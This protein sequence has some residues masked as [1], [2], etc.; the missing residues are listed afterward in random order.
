MN[1]VRDYTDLDLSIFEQAC[2]LYLESIH[3]TYFD[4]QMQTG[5]KLLLELR[6]DVATL[7]S[8]VM[9]HMADD[10][11]KSVEM[12]S[13][14]KVILKGMTDLHPFI[15]L[16]LISHKKSPESVRK[17]FLAMAKD[18][19]V[20]LIILALRYSSLYDLNVYDAPLRKKI[21]RETL[22]VYVPLAGRLGIYTIKRPLED[23]CFSFLSEED[24]KAMQ[25]AFDR[26]VELHEKTVNSLV[27]IIKKYLLTKGVVAEVSGRVK[28]LY[29][30]YS[31]LKRKGGGSLEDIYDLLALRIIVKDQMDCYSVL[32]H[33]NNEWIALSGRFKD[34]IAMP[35]ANG[36]RSLHTTVLGMITDFDRPV[37]VQ[38]RTE[39]MHREAEFGIAAHWWY[40]EEG[41]K[42]QDSAHHFM[43]RSGYQQKLQWMK[44]LVELQEN[45][46]T[47]D[48]SSTMELFADSIFV[49]TMNGQ[50]IELPKGATP[51]DFAYY[52]SS[53]LGNHCFKAKINGKVVPLDYELKTGD[54]VFILKKL[55][56]V[57]NLYWLSV[58]QTEKAKKTI[59]GF[60]FEQGKVQ[61]LNRGIEMMNKQLK[62]MK[63]SP[64]DDRL[65]LMA[66][67]DGRKF[68]QEE[69]KAVLV[70]LAQGEIDSEVLIKRIF[71]RD[72]Y[73]QKQLV[74]FGKLS[75]SKSKIFIAGD[76]TLKTKI[77]ACCS[78]S[79]AHKI[80]GYVTR[81]G[82]ISV[83]RKSCKVLS[84]LD[85][86]RLLESWWNGH[87]ASPKRAKAVVQVKRSHLLSA[88]TQVLQKEGVG[89]LGFEH[90]QEGQ[91][92][93]LIF[94]LQL[95]DMKTM[96]NVVKVWEGMKDVVSVKVIGS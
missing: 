13:D 29:S 81:G 35:K 72:A 2:Q 8:Y 46:R 7:V 95:S 57:P 52:I 71:P 48:D 26:R 61:L 58:V 20:V 80:I 33:I 78:P 49:M 68:T 28:G 31:K 34:Y 60:L 14:V 21:A 55:E 91:I 15:E 43:N 40:E 5:L 86:S 62:R 83:H 22:E 25:T 90:E 92:Y 67:Y 39:E 84:S 36:Y 19:R 63:K 47:S 27:T 38:I 74:Q 37:E 4:L 96:E 18:L 10:L 12:S 6:A 87:K 93:I 11:R 17:M 51:L 54:K 70:S 45:M 24:F 76:N 65:S 69:R 50:V 44:N 94:D 30:T 53:S 66:E 82:F 75:R 64:L 89:L 32:G 77:A 85:T 79:S 1:H 23:R 9:Y 3:R 56:V 88:L 73:F 42:K 41:I 59:Q 16:G